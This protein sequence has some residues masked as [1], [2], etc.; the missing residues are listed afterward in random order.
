MAKRK[1]FADKGVADEEGV[2]HGEMG[3]V[4]QAEEDGELD[5]RK[6]SILNAVVREY[7]QTAQPVGSGHLSGAPGIEVSPATVR[8]E[9]A[10]LERE[11]YLTQP[12][13]SAGRVPTD[14]GYRFFVDHLTELGRLQPAKRQKIREFY[15]QVHGEVEELLERTST[16]LAG[17]TE[18][19]AVVV[20]PMNEGAPVRGVHVVR[21]SSRMAMV[22]V[23]LGD[24]SVE[25]RML[26]LDEEVSDELLDAAGRHL[27]E[28]L[29]D[30]SLGHSGEIRATG[31]PAVD[32]LCA[33]A[34]ALLGEVARGELE[35]VFVEGSSHIALAFDAVETV[36]SVLAILEQQL[37]VV[38]LVEHLLDR[39]LS[40][41]IGTE[42]G[43]EPLASC[44]L[45]LAPVCVGGEV[46]GTLGLLGP[47]RMDYPMALAAVDAVGEQLSRT[48]AFQLG[49][50]MEEGDG[51]E[52]SK[53]PRKPSAGTS[54][55][56]SAG[57]FPGASSGPSPRRLPK[58]RKVS[59]RVTEETGSGG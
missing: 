48:L 30:R 7:I 3:G 52:A 12:H 41:A 9:M 44:S 14:R 26:E 28:C 59:E 6:A 21:L 51:G 42:H 20:G 15:S 19:A 23:V 2:A 16:L 22:L 37:V 32:A 53:T 47:T 11:G 24:G 17:L 39:G 54:H 4:R 57:S 35:H 33:K 56:S 49:A 58:R 45:V 31:D 27:Q 1:S 34:L 36:R 13:T 46:T 8:A 55:R 25:K 40:V 50:R 10:S 29:R 5:S 43:F 18:Y 38:E